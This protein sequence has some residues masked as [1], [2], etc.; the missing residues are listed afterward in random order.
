MPLD[1]PMP[2]HCP[3]LPCFRSSPKQ[4]KQ[5]RRQANVCGTSFSGLWQRA[6]LQLAA[7]AASLM[8]N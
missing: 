3:A 5:E 4:V 6:F 1:Q 2:G 7:V 8:P